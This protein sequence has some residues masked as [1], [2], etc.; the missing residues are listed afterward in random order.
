MRDERTRLLV[1]CPV[2]NEEQNIDYFFGRL[3]AVFAAVD[4]RRYACSLLF[5]NN[6]SSDRT[7][8]LIQAIEQR[9][10]WVNHVTLSRNFGYQL[11]V[12][13][14]LTTGDAD[15]YMTCDVDCEDPPELVH[16]FLKEIERGRDLVYGIRNNRPDSWL[17]AKCRRGFYSV[18][19][20]LGDYKIVPYMAEFAMLRRHVRDELVVNASTFPFIRAEVGYVGFDILGVP[21]RREDR[22][23][24]ETHY[25]Y[26][27]NFRFAIAGILSSTTFPLRAALY[28]LPV[29]LAVMALICSLYF[30]ALLRFE[31]AILFAVTL[32]S[33]YSMTALAFQSIYLARTYQNGLGR[34]RFIVDRKLS[35]LPAHVARDS[36]AETPVTTSSIRGS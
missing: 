16:T 15:L 20:A 24:G 36:D 17:M 18:L 27:G 33:A 6:R 19:R 29:A 32:A 10:A 11:S 23:H 5:T 14:G 35:Y 30:S 8:E 21:Y 28:L 13:S 26:L 2:F 22:M 7:L 34:S 3:Q 12:L 9:H 31:T 1:I 25:N 4:Q